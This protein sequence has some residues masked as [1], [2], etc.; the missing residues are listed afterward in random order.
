MCILSVTVDL[1]RPDRVFNVVRYPTP[2]SVLFWDVIVLSAYMLLNIIIGWTVLSYERRGGVA[3]PLWC[4]VLIYI[5]IP[6]AFSIHTVTAFLYAGL[7]GRGFWLTAI[8]APRFL[9]SAFAS[10]PALLILLCYAAKKWANYDVGE[11]AI[12]SISKI[13]TYAMVAS[14]FFFGCELFTVYYSQIPE[15]MNHFAYMFTGL[16]GH[17][18]FVPIMW[19]CAIL[20]IAATVLLIF[21]STRYNLTILPIACAMVF[22]SLWI[23]KG[24]ALVVV[25]FIPT[26]LETITEYVP[27]FPESAIT[28]GI[29]A[30]G[31]LVLTLL[32]KVAI[33]VKYEAAA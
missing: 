7:P 9:G 1:G 24:L 21:P 31:A 22:A 6:W 32:Y 13:V 11:E 5:S 30:I 29:W 15:H 4:K 10:G 3:P 17:Y 27:T 12:R 33:G 8:M 16:H 25:G 28:L 18:G 20:A 26:P 2:N 14:L 19:I 23:E